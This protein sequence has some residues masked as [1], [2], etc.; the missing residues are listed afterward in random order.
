MKFHIRI[1]ISLVLSISTL[2]EGLTNNC[3]SIHIDD[4]IAMNSKR[5]ELY[6]QMTNGESAFTSNYL[7]NAERLAYPV[8][9]AFD[10]K[11]RKYQNAGIPLLCLDAIDMSETPAF[12]YQRVQPRTSYKDAYIPSI[13]NLNSRVKNAMI[14]NY[15]SAMRILDEEVHKMEED[16]HY[17]CLTRHFIESIRR[18]MFLT[19]YYIISAKKKGLES[20][21][22]LLESFIETQ[23]QTLYLTKSIDKS[24]ANIQEAGT[25]IICQD[26]PVIP[27][28]TDEEIRSFYQI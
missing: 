11:A 17:N 19:P 25:P 23:L 20:P 28:P 16:I 1:I 2:A 26:V 24:A 9:K 12:S 7:I 18:T 21:R 22:K 13:R 6:S 5:R 3:L 27:L 14:K 8:S 15:F 4:A 10:K